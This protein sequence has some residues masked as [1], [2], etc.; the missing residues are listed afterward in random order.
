MSVPE[1]ETAMDAAGYQM[2]AQISGDEDYNVD[3][4]SPE[5]RVPNMAAVLLLKKVP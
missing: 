3:R 2:A 4:Y 5:Y 1:V